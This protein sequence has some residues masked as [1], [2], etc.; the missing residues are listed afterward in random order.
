MPLPIFLLASIK[1]LFCQ[2][3]EAFRILIAR[4]F[5]S[6]DDLLLIGRDGR[7]VLVCLLIDIRTHVYILE[8]HWI[9]NCFYGKFTGL[10]TPVGL[11]Q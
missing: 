8:F 2:T 1:I 4:P 10:D 11:F 7:Q 3:K 5:Y 9:R 6:E